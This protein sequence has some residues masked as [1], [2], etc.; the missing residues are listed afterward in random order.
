MRPPRSR[1]VV[2]LSGSC[3]TATRAQVERA[4]SDVPSTAIDPMALAG[5]ERLVART[6]DWA[7]G[8]LR[9]GRLLIYSSAGPEAVRLAH[10]RLGRTEAARL[11][12]GAFARIATALASAGVRTF[13]VAG[14]E[15]AGAVVQA[16][17]IGVIAFGEEID[18]GVPWT[19]SL[20]PEGFALAMKSGNFGSPDLFAKAIEDVA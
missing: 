9:H 13:V 10:A 7:L 14:G 19:Y 4:A 1:P 16:L 2:V 11:I 12:E 17:G 15:T 6:I 5:D 18:P 8:N 20:E 3:S